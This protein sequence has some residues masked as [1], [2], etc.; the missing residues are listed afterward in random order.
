MFAVQGYRR[1]GMSW[2]WRK[3]MRSTGVVEVTYFEI[4]VT[5]DDL[6]SFRQT[7]SLWTLRRQNVS[8]CF[9]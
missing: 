5:C 9:D 2:N 1:R 7:D 3:T 8:N 4:E 6:N